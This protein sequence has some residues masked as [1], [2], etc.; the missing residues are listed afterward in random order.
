MFKKI[1]PLWLVIILVI[2]LGIYFIIRYTGEGDRNFRAIMIEFNPKDITEAI[3]TIPGN[4]EKTHLRKEGS[5]WKV[6]I[7]DVPYRA[8]TNSVYSMIGQLSRLETKRFAG[9]GKE[10]WTKYELTDSNA[11]NVK[12]FEGKKKI[13]DLMVGKFDYIQPPQNQPNMGMQQNPGEMN[14]FVRL[15]DEKEVYVVDG[16]LKMGVGREGEAFRDKN[17]VGELRNN[18]NRVSFNYPEGPMK[19][20][21]R[22]D[23]NWTLDGNL[24]DSVKSMKYITLISRLVGQEFI[25]EDI[26]LGNPSHTVTIEGNNF[27]PIEINAYPVTDTNYNYVLVSSK[28]PEALFSGK[29]SDLFERLMV[30]REAFQ[31]DPEE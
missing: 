5:E 9:K 2:L 16:F 30:G 25:Y 18:I 12:L 31:A 15:T 23:K 21:R 28:N 13:A 1:K 8:D 4:E 11:V 24:A 3:V 26:Q 7:N 17:L 29:K 22:E 14:T 27:T 10:A 20:E 19:L 6:F